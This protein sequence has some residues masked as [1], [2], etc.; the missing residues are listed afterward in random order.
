MHPIVL[1]ILVVVT[2]ISAF[3]AASKWI[4]CDNLNA[5]LNEKD[6]QI[7]DALTRLEREMEVSEK[8]GKELQYYKD[9]YQ[10]SIIIQAALDYSK[11]VIESLQG[12][13]RKRDTKGRFL[14][15]NQQ[16]PSHRLTPGLTVKNPTEDEAKAIF[17]EANRVGIRIFN[18]HRKDLDHIWVTDCLSISRCVLNDEQIKQFFVTASEFIARMQPQSNE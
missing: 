10:Q 8:L 7:K 14:P 5:Q 1:L 12:K 17:A 4:Q 13:I 15:R 3:I 16:K 6:T 9:T 18:K 2:A 11:G